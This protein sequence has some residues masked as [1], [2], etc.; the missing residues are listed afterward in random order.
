[1]FLKRMFLFMLTNILIIATISIVLSV[2]GVGPYIEY[3]G[4]QYG[5]NY[6]SLMIF[7]LIWGM[8]GSIISLMLSKVMAKWMMK[9]KI[10]DPATSTDQA[11]RDLYG[12]VEKLSKAAGLPSTPEVGIYD[13]PEVNAFATGPTKNRALVAVSSGL[14]Q[15]MNREELE[16]VIGHEVAHIANGDMVTMTLIQGIVNAFV[17]FFA[18]VLAFFV[19]NALRGNNDSEG[20]SYLIQMVLIIVFQILFG[21]LGMMVVG[22]FSRW[23]EFR[24]DAGSARLG[25][26]Q[27]MIAAL[28]ALMGTEDLID[29]EQQAVASLK[30]SGKAKGMMALMSTH[31][32]LSQRIA[33]LQQMN[34]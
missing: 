10:I 3:Y 6:Q 20:P 11:S 26:R 17:M 16:G 19:S 33:R 12:A 23:R 25:G 30:I 2:L 18:R 13:S 28:K 4:G 7:C 8:G 24:A 31:P 22:S 34:Y 15:R 29:N 1:M 21:F 5:I 32:A 27:K 9:V 14:L